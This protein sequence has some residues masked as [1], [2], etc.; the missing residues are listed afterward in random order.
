MASTRNPRMWYM[1]SKHM[2]GEL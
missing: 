2:W 1:A